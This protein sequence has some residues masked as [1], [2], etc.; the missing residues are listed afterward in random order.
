[1]KP[2]QP[3]G[4]S[5]PRGRLSQ[6]WMAA[7]HGLPRT[8]LIRST[9]AARDESLFCAV[10]ARTFGSRWCRVI[11]DLTIARIARRAAV[12]A[13]FLALKARRCLAEQSEETFDDMMQALQSMHD[14]LTTIYCDIKTEE[15][16]ND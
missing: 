1:M 14:N 16:T 7:R 9:N 5:E 8:V 13:E 4:A 12:C 2:H 15:P 10:A 6:S 3:T 11:D